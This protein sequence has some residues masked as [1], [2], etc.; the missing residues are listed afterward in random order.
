[1]L[2]IGFATEF[3]TLWDVTK[4]TKY[5]TDVN[6]NHWPS[7]EV[8][9][10]NYIQNVSTDLER[11]KAKY[12]EL[13]INEELRGKTTSWERKAEDLTPQILKFGKYRGH[14]IQ[15]IAEKDFDYILWLLENCYSAATKN[16]CLE[17]PLVIE[18][19]AEMERKSEAAK[20]LH[21]V[22]ESGEVE[23]TF[24]SNPNYSCE[25]IDL[26]SQNARKIGAL[27]CT[28]KWEPVSESPAKN[29]DWVTIEK[30]ESE[31][32]PYERGFS[33][34]KWKGSATFHILDQSFNTIEEARKCAEIQILVNQHKSLSDYYI[35]NEYTPLLNQR[36]AEA[37]IGEGNQI[38][39][40]FNEVSQVGGMYPYN[41]GVINGK[42]MR[43]KG[44]KMKLNLIVLETT[45]YETYVRQIA[46][47]SPAK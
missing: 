38:L 18:H 4:E 20:A 19:F 34:G 30:A 6:G 43:I 45:R 23:I 14:S 40:I 21:P 11:V 39:V 47:I 32:S 5:F 15:D 26:I 9:H 28:L 1:M 33:I 22:I 29:S 31:H 2:T 27:P 44:K 7:T 41:M 42:A 46:I 25:D 37:T 16:A 35:V 12:P 8:T 10:F 17:L 36:Y 24:T 13:T 3:Y